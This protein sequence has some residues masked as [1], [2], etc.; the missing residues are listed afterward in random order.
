MKL[1]NLLSGILP[2]KEKT[3]TKVESTV[4]EKNVPDET[5]NQVYHSPEAQGTWYTGVAAPTYLESD[6]WFGEPVLS[7]KS[8]EVVNQEAEIK[9]QNE[10]NKQELISSG[11]IL[12]D[13]NI[14][15]KMYEIATKN[16]NT[17]AE[18]QGASEN[19]QEGPGGW[20]SGTGMGQFL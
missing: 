2:K 20:N 4:E 6:S 3:E 14:H 9:R 5:L 19:F 8:W 16:W 1:R 12:E 10:E 15:Q 13:D 18:T 7:E 17:V 11:I